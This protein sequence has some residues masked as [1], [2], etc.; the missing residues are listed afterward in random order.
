MLVALRLP[1]KQDRDAIEGWVKGQ[2]DN[3][4]A[5]EVLGSLSRLQRREGWIWAPEQDVLVRR[6]FPPDHH[7]RFDAHA[8]PRRGTR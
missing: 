2:A 7:L 3:A 8:G 1:A 6:T 5:A 4:L